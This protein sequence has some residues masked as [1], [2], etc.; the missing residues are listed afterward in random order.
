VVL[1]RQ[2]E[3]LRRTRAQERGFDSPVAWQEI[4]QG[5]EIV[6]ARRLDATF[7]EGCLECL[8]DRLL[9]LNA[10]IRGRLGVRAAPAL[11]RDRRSRSSSSASRQS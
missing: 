3:L 10:T 8:L 9:A 5:V 2:D 1:Q 7:D 4:A 6:G 11:R